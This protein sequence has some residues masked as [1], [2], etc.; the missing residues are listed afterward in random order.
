[1]TTIEEGAEFEVR[2]AN[3]LIPDEEM[4]ER[5]RTAESSLK[6]HIEETKPDLIITSGKSAV[7]TRTA[8]NK[9]N[10]SLEGR[11]PVLRLSADGNHL[12]YK[13]FEPEEVPEAERLRRLSLEIEKL[14]AK[15]P[16][17]TPESRILFV[18]EYIDTG[19]KAYTTLA[20]MHQL[21]YRNVRFAA[22]ATGGVADFNDPVH[23]GQKTHSLSVERGDVF[24]GACELVRSGE[25][26]F[27]GKVFAASSDLTLF[28]YLKELSGEMTRAKVALWETQP[29]NPV[30]QMAGPGIKGALTEALRKIRDIDLPE[31]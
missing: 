31:E 6:R 5:I 22:I 21:G 29:V 10:S 12:I 11:I 25:L 16:Q 18:D 7:V 30:F 3:D 2:I 9:I 27:F 15:H 19:I 14:K 23:V 1:M 8:L 4:V 17:L 20:R 26:N 28:G 24:T 13:Q